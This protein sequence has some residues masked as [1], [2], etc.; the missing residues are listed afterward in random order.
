M[1]PIHASKQAGKEASED[2]ETDGQSADAAF[3]DA[4]IGRMQRGLRN[5]AFEVEREQEAL[6]SRLDELEERLDEQLGAEDRRVPLEAAERDGKEPQPGAVGRGR[7]ERAP[8]ELRALRR[9]VAELQRSVAEVRQQQLAR[10]RRRRARLRMLRVARG[11]KARI[12]DRFFARRLGRLTHHDP[13]QM[14]LPRRYRREIRLDDPPVISIVTPSYNQ[15]HFLERTIRSVVEQ[16]YPRLEYIVQ[17]GGSTDDTEGVLARHAERLHH[18]EMR[19]DDGHAHAIN[20]GFEHASGD[21]MAFLNSDDLLLPGALRYVG[22]YFERHPEVD[23]VYGHRILVDE[24]DMEIGRWV[25]PRH[26][27]EVLSWADFVPQETLFWRRRIWEKAGGYMDQSWP[28]ALDW[29]L[30]LRLRSAGARTVRLPRFLGAFRIHEAQKTSAIM[31]T[32][33][34][35]EAAALRARIHGREV[36]RPEISAAVKPYM[37]RHLVLQK[38]YRARLLRY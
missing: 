8:R 4:E 32:Q 37:R 6:R 26:D 22:R 16:G 19:A 9:Q 33:G 28:F 38:L 27:D 7:R 14:K 31:D 24:N 13:K 12:R 29:D 20:L 21:V 17:D 3:G 36:S 23:A 25:M 5:L 35:K 11:A 30:L 10:T 2:L 18:Y 1:T 34:Q 15:G